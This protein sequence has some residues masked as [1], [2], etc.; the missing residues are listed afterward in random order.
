M[1]N[2][3]LYACDGCQQVFRPEDLH[4][5]RIGPHTWIPSTASFIGRGP[6]HSTEPVVSTS[7]EDCIQHMA[8]WHR[9]EAAYHQRREE[10]IQQREVDEDRIV[11][12]C[13]TDALL[14]QLLE[15]GNTELAVLEGGFPPPNFRGGEER[16]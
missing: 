6:W 8:A 16:S 2:I 5:G 15:S 13:R 11:T 14:Q 4:E 7:E 10:A 1:H 9:D 12:A 3:S